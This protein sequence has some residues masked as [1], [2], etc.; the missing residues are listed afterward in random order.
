MSDARIAIV[1][2]STAYLPPDVARQYD[3][4]VAPQLLI[5]GEETLL[6][7]VDIKPA[8]FYAR[9]KTDPVFPKTSQVTVPYIQELF[10]NLRESHDAILAILI[11]DD[12]SG[13]INSA[14]QAKALLP[15]VE[16]EIVDSR[17]TAMALG[18]VVLAA[19]RAREQGKSLQ[20]VAQVARE[21]VDKVGVIFAVET[22]EFL[23][24]GGRIGGARRFLGTALNI[25]PILHV[26]GGKVEALDQV[27][28]RKKSLNYV[29]DAVGERVSGHENVRIATLHAASEADADFLMNAA[30]ERFDP[31]EALTSEVSP[32]VGAHAGPGTVGLCWCVDI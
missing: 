10:G 1:T 9:L 8:A 12:L 25:K 21:A 13:T 2:D 5:W 27:R 23:H 30:M 20:E 29:L 18:F 3:I 4:H 6:D 7:D 26:H 28:T 11:S 22:L 15:D 24:R 32:V 17:T 19:A 14:V 16:I 31:V